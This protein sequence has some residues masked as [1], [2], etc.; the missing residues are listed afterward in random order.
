MQA[1]FLVLIS[2]GPHSS[3]RFNEQAKLHASTLIYFKSLYTVLYLSV[4]FKNDIY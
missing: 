1:N 2:W 3:V 4:N